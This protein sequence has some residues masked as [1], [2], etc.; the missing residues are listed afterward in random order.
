MKKTDNRLIISTILLSFYIF[1]FLGTEYLFDNIVAT[2]AN[3]RS[4]V[5]AQGYV[6]GA[7]IIGFIIYPI[8]MEIKN[9]SKQVIVVI[10]GF[11]VTLFYS[12]N[13]IEKYTPLIIVAGCLFIIF[14]CIGSNI[15]FQVTKMLGHSKD[16]AKV[17]G[18]SY[19]IGLMLQFISNN[20]ISNPK[21][22]LMLIAVYMMLTC[23]IIVKVE[24]GIFYE[25]EAEPKESIDIS[26]EKDDYR[27]CIQN[28]V[29]KKDER[30][31][32]LIALLIVVVILMSCVFST[33]D[34]VV[35][36]YHA[37]GTTDIGQLPCILLALSGIVAGILFDIKKR[38][39]MSIIMYSVTLLS[40]ISI[41]VIVTGGSFMVG[42]I[43]FYL[44]AG[45]FVTYFSTAFMELSLYTE[46]V[47]V[48][49][50][51]GRCV[52]NF[53][54]AFIA[55]GSIKLFESKNVVL[56]TT[57]SL[58]LFVL[59]SITMLIYQSVY[60]KMKNDTTKSSSTTD[61][62]K[63]NEFCQQYK[64]TPREKEVLKELIKS[65]DSVQNIAKSLYISRAAL[66]RHI[67]N[68]TNK[69]DTENRVE[70]IKFFYRWSK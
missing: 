4:V 2:I 28:K 23:Y 1:I 9:I 8:V 65:N 58:V 54:A 52:N 50:G 66:Y 67:S 14:G 35:T 53:C 6:L 33:L 20:I 26:N 25:N 55:L 64:L 57:I 41:L 47:R 60:A 44:S 5:L 70:L 46:H 30:S 31:T 10:S 45:F 40:T 18:I 48:F 62:E 19:G 42:L 17:V 15:Y 38:K 59:I 13:T 12:I 29:R 49:A 32:G 27:I 63:V 36:L 37:K 3:S 21:I 56:I 68:I 34:N 11:S 16:L 43:V 39:F 7:S 51:L 61:E 22:E 69:T 24:S